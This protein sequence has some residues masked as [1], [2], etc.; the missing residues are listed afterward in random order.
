MIIYHAPVATLINGAKGNKAPYD[1][2]SWDN[3]SEIDLLARVVAGEA[4]GSSLAGQQSEMVGVAQ[5]AFRRLNHSGYE[6]LRSVLVNGHMFVFTLDDPPQI[7]AARASAET[8]A[9]PL[10]SSN[11]GR[12]EQSL[13]IAVGVNQGW[14]YDPRT[15]GMSSFW[16]SNGITTF[17]PGGVTVQNYPTLP[18][19][20]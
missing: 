6:D 16:G 14:L 4:G 9:N 5:V 15:A 3:I 17:N 18:Q 11:T 1:K 12:Y 7:A 10:N 20:Q 2:S 19:Y 13:A 8:W